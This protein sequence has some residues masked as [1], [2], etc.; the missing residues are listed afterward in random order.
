MKTTLETSATLSFVRK[1]V[2]LTGSSKISESEKVIVQWKQNEKFIK[3]VEDV[4]YTRN[5]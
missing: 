5:E 4:N 3:E 1:V 2:D